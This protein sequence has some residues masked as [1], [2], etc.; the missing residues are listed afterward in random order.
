MANEADLHQSP[1]QEKKIALFLSPI[2]FFDRSHIPTYVLGSDYH[3][4]H[5]YLGRCLPPMEGQTCMCFFERVCAYI[6]LYLSI[7]ELE[8]FMT[9]CLSMFVYSD[10]SIMDQSI[11]VQTTYVTATNN[12]SQQARDSY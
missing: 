7:I 10:T 6:M 3:S 4:S 9:Y 5:H 12:V 11:H 1:F 8:P 2:F